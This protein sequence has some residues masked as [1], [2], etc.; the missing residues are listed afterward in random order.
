MRTQFLPTL[1]GRQF[2]S[3]VKVNEAGRVQRNYWTGHHRTLNSTDYRVA[4]GASESCLNALEAITPWVPC[5]KSDR[6]P[7]ATTR[8]GTT[9][10]VLLHGL[11]R[12]RHSLRHLEADLRVRGWKVAAINYPSA[13]GSIQEHAELVAALL[14][15]T[16]GYSR[17]IF[18]T[19]SLGGLVARA[20]LATPSRCRDRMTVA[21]L[22]QM[23][24]PNNGSR[25][26]RILRDIPIIG[27]VLTKTARAL[28]DPATTPEPSLD[29]P[30]IVIA[31]GTRRYKGFNPMLRGDNDGVVRVDETRLCRPH[32]FHLIHTIHTFL[33]KHPE[34]LRL[35]AEAVE[36]WSTKQECQNEECRS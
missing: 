10:I 17:V 6:N 11:Y 5:E 31:G 19:H 14:E 12:S 28:G 9:L 13:F 30:V 18:V 26:S 25:L 8:S 32:A 36:S 2:W 3:D 24:S 7:R 35:V 4:F 21:G 22:V 27:T 16:E 20:V 1:G 23:G 29:I 33:M 34:T 15:E